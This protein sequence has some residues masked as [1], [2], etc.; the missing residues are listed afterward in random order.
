MG[1]SNER[2]DEIL[3]VDFEVVIRTASERAYFRLYKDRV[4]DTS[5]T[6]D[7]VIESYV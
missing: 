5:N 4:L 3:C 1:Q 7:R 2:R 6:F